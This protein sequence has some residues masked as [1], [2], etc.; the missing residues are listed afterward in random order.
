MR[1]SGRPGHL[2]LC[3]RVLTLRP[4]LVCQIPLPVLESPLL[5]GGYPSCARGGSAWPR[6]VPRATY[7]LASVGDIRPR[8]IQ[9]CPSLPGAIF[10]TLPGLASPLRGGHR[11]G[12]GVDPLGA[13]GSIQPWAPDSYRRLAAGSC[14]AA[15]YAQ[16]CIR[17]LWHRLEQPLNPAWCV[18]S[19]A[20]AVN[21][22]SASW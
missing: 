11:H 4:S 10:R 9:F 18:G 12:F 7:Y 5:F 17:I 2:E 14:R 21:T 13:R 19:T 8:P 16:E 3:K 15:H 6:V 20:N 1:E 22:S